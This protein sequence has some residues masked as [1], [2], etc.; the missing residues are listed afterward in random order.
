MHGQQNKKKMWVV[1][2]EVFIA[3]L[4]KILN[5]GISAMQFGA[6]V[7]AVLRFAVVRLRGSPFCYLEDGDSKPLRN[8]G[9]FVIILP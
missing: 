5:L 1:R 3:M 9:D 6:K 4:M 2:H 8:A 7:P